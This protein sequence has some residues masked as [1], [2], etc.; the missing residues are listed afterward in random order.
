MKNY[1]K[2]IQK[3]K[4]KELKISVLKWNE[5][6]E[7]ND[8]SYSVLDIQ[9]YLEYIIEKHEIFN[10]NAL[11]RIYVNITKN[12][13]TFKMKTGYNLELLTSERIKI[14]WKH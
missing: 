10:D 11:V 1:K 3:K 7:L 2:V 14:T 8:G 13:I 9:H 12:R 5:E 4:K 6:F